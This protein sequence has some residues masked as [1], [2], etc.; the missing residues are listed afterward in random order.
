MK[1]AYVTFLM[2]FLFGV[3]L[4]LAPAKTS[5][6]N[7]K[8]R[9]AE[10][11]I[12]NRY[13]VV[14]E[15]QETPDREIESAG[16][17]T[18]LA[19]EYAMRVDRVYD[20]AIKGYSAE[21]SIDEAQRLSMDPRVKYVEED[22]IVS[23]AET[24]IN[25]GWALDRIDQR[26]ASYDSAYNYTASGTGV[27][28]YILDSGIQTAHVALQ[29]RARAGFNAFPD[30]PP[31][32]QCNGHGTGVAGVVGSSVHGVAKNV[33]LVSVRVLPCTGNGTVSD[34]IAGIEWVT[35]NAVRPAVANMSLQTGYSSGLNDAVRASIATGVT[36][37]VA[38]GN[39]TANA[40][41]YSPSSLG[42]AITVGA[43]NSSD[44][45][46]QYSNFGPCV[47]LF[48]PGEG[49]KTIWNSSTTA[50][51]YASGTSF[52]SPYVT[53]AAA[54][55]LESHPGATPQEVHAAITSN[56]TA[57]LVS[58]AGFDSPNMLLFS[59]LGNPQAT[60]PT[61]TPEPTPTPTPEP[62]PPPTPTPEPTPV[63]TPTP[64]ATPTLTPTPTPTPEPPP[65]L[66][67][68]VMT[69]D[70]R[71]LL[72]ATVSISDN[73]GMIRTSMTGSFGYYRFDDVEAGRTYVMRVGSRRYRFASCI[74]VITETPADVN[75]VGLE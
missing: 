21:M 34:A 55:Y 52:A 59:A 53:G 41:E 39:N 23:D 71:G 17:A 60:T 33:S 51:T 6:Q 57:N 24:Q 20:T 63:P 7:D 31:I 58:A 22:S 38:A 37:V 44:T 15:D 3:F 2:L 65:T 29:G 45:R 42:Q 27:N 50:V 25:P 56:A 47:D 68:R 35:A 48:A 46:V 74:I 61:P 43:T 75:F 62:T 19:A 28:V 11:A 5:G 13:I 64:V 18:E 32:E 30:S 4:Y 1:R 72:N 40:C 10:Q 36:Y 70:G 8:F 66:S 67:G 69:P 54:L 14:F 12:P 49:V 26:T 73:A 9:R 16:R